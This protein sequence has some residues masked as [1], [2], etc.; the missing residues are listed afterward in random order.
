MGITMQGRRKA[1]KYGGTR[2]TAMGIISPGSD[3]ANCFARPPRTPREQ[4]ELSEYQYTLA[5]INHMYIRP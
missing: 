3:R 2:S 5:T 1:W 4:M